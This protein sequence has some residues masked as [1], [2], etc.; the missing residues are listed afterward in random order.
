MNNTN[1]TA[2]SHSNLQIHRY[3]AI[4]GVPASFVG[5]IFNTSMAYLLLTDKYFKKPTYQLI[6]V[7]VLSDILSSTA[8]FIGY[9]FFA[10][11]NVSYHLGSILCKMLLFISMMSFGISIMNLSLIS[12][13]RY[14][15]I[16][17]P[18]SS[19]Y[20]KHKI[21]FL[22]V[23][24]LF[25]YIASISISLPILVYASSHPNLSASCDIL[26]ITYA[27]AIWEFIF[28]FIM[29]IIPVSMMIIIYSKLAII[30]KNHVRPG[31]MAPNRAEAEISQKKR[32]TKVLMSITFSTV[33]FSWPH[34]ATMVGT[35]ITRKTIYQ[36]S[37]ESHI[38]YVLVY[39]ALAIT[40]SIFVVN[41][42]LLLK[43]DHNI[44]QKFLTLWRR[45]LCI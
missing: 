40:L 1:I 43:F 38:Q 3:V 33:L 6:L 34:F 4:C 24:E 44:R 39:F 13:H 22:I 15:I 21:Q 10:I 32:F 36:I 45:R 7:S 26:N 18:L 41:P 23:C 17:R 31:Y 30:R 25:I 27:I 2:T 9:I 20:R 8:A 28:T 14:F 12:V 29:Y 37:L 16:A 35:A 42:F 19:F 5:L 11:V